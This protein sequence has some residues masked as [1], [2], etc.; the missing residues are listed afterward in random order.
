[1]PANHAMI[2]NANALL[3]HSRIVEFPEKLIGRLEPGADLVKTAQ[4]LGIVT[5]EE[6]AGKMSAMPDGLKEVLR[7]AIYSALT[8][9]PDRVPVTFAWLE[10]HY[11]LTISEVP[12]RPPGMTIIVRSPR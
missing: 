12:G 2:N 11:E 3:N 10:G 6:Q 7:A 1:M 9:R 8:R 5:T 4:E